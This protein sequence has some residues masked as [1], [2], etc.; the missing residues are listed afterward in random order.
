MKINLEP[1]ALQVIEA[2]ELLSE[3]GFIDPAVCYGIP[4]PVTAD[5]LMVETAAIKF[6]P[7]ANRL[8]ARPEVEIKGTNAAET[9][10]GEKGKT[11]A[12][13]GLGGN[14]VLLGAEQGDLISGGNGNDRV[15]GA[16]GS[17]FLYGD[18]GDDMLK[19]G[20]GIDY[21]QG[22]RGDDQLLG[23]GGGDQFAIQKNKGLDTILDYRDGVDK[24]ATFNVT[25]EKLT[26]VQQGADTEIRVGNTAIAL[27]KNVS[28]AAL[29]SEDF[30]VPLPAVV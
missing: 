6:K 14:D 9:V 30:V 23:G 3:D 4:E 11:N 25:F 20:A 12:I 16:G 24:L 27:L 15:E 10:R 19:G 22:D 5:K 18:A 2:P 7:T 1:D 29:T 21:L 17:D 8:L 28:A 26:I 13:S